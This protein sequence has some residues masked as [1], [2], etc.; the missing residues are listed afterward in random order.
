MIQ[1]SFPRGQSQEGRVMRGGG[2]GGFSTVHREEE[3][4][5]EEGG[6]RLDT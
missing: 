6:G 2:P 3:E 5:Q 1:E 4:E